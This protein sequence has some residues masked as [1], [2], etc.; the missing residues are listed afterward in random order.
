MG[1][2][3]SQSTRIQK[4]TLT[5]QPAYSSECTPLQGCNPHFQ[6]YLIISQRQIEEKNHFDTP[7]LEIIWC[8]PAH[9]GQFFWVPCIISVDRAWS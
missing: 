6:K 2:S 5:Q 4:D 8:Y 7:E 3:Q 1:A 9:L